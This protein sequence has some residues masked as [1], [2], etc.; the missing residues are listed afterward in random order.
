MFEPI[1]LSARWRNMPPMTREHI[2]RCPPTW[3]RQY[4]GNVYARPLKAN[5]SLPP[6][7]SSF[8][9]LGDICSP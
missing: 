8:T 9:V 7:A 2:L 5:L 3:I 6:R 1:C 4:A